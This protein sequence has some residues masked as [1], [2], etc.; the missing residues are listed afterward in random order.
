[1]KFLRCSLLLE[2]ISM[3]VG[4]LKIGEIN[5]C[6][7][8]RIASL[9]GHEI[10]QKKTNECTSIKSIRFYSMNEYRS[11][12]TLTKDHWK[13]HWVHFDVLFL[14]DNFVQDGKKIMSSG[15]DESVTVMIKEFPMMFDLFG[16]LRCFWV[17]YL[18]ML[19]K[20]M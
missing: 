5:H 14:L 9:F 10:K 17:I 3:M 6:L 15:R 4:W 7:I 16:F 11:I 18:V 2:V 12:I 8:H 1:M 13:A 19:R 20:K